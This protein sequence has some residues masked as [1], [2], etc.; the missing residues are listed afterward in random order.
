MEWY[1]LGTIVGANLGMFLWSVKLSR[2]DF[3]HTVR[4]IEEI[5]K[6][7]RDFHGRLCGLEEKYKQFQKGNK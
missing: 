4:I 7:S 3:L 5:K 6:E 2:A 1:Q